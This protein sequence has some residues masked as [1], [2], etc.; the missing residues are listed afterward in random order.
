MALLAGFGLVAIG[1]AVAA[2]VMLRGDDAVAALEGASAGSAVVAPGS[3]APATPS[4]AATSA[5]GITPEPPRPADG[6]ATMAELEA[7]RS[8]GLTALGPLAQ[9]YPN[10]P[11]VLKALLLAHAGSSGGYGAA[12]G[13]A[14]HLFGVSPEATADEDV[15]RVILRTANAQPAAAAA[16]FDVMS[17]HMGSRG[18]D[19]LY[20]LLIAPGIGKFPKDRAEKLLK[21]DRVKKQATP[22]LLVANDLRAANGCGRKRLFARATEVGDGR[23]LPHLKPLALTN[24]CRPSGIFGRLSGDRLDCYPCLGSR[25]EL[26]AAIEAIEGRITT[27]GSETR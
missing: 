15:R 1:A 27:Q 5:P 21:D 8:G 18:P 19:L 4:G 20:E 12:M 24:A 22:A 11:A 6:V 14:R 16:A 13:V 7:A 26:R 9:R 17:Q 25:A 23:S 10:D 3:G 2:A